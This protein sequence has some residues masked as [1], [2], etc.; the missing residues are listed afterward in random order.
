MLPHKHHKSTHKLTQQKTANITLAVKQINTPC[1][2][3][4][5]NLC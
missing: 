4:I 5:S 1:L 2:L 3:K